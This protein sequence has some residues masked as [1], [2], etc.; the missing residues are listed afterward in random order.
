MSYDSIADLKAEARTRR[1]PDPSLSDHGD[2]L[3]SKPLSRA[4]FRPGSSPA[5]GEASGNLDQ[6][7]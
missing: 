2:R 5:S 6:G 1:R 4:G 3:E 7:P